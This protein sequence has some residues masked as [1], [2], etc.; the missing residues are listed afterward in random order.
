[1]QFVVKT[2][3]C[4]EAHV[5][6]QTAGVS[7][8]AGGFER[9]SRSTA[10]DDNHRAGALRGTGGERGNRAAELVKVGNAHEARLARG[11][12]DQEN[13]SERRVSIEDTENLVD[14]HEGTKP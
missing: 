2:V 3:A 7:R 12:H 11:D 4:H 6:R 10:R 13:A 5:A 1:M 8:G 14:H 9:G